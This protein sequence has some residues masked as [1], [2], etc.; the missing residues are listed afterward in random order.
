M[1]LEKYLNGPEYE[2]IMFQRRTSLYNSVQA[3][4][5]QT[6]V[7]RPTKLVKFFELIQSYSQMSR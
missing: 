7:W 2:M 1:D 3:D 5:C 6:E 4:F